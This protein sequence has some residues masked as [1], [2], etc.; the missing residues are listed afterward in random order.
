MGTDDASACYRDCG[1]A[2]P[3]CALYFVPP[4]LLD[5]ASGEHLRRSEYSAAWSVNRSTANGRAYVGKVRSISY[6][7]LSTLFSA[8]ARLSELAV[9][10]RCGATCVPERCNV[11]VI[12]YILF[13]ISISTKFMNTRRAAHFRAVRNDLICELCTLLVTQ[14]MH[15]AVRT[16]ADMV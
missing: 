1:E 4:L 7:D 16:Q 3:W 14:A 8:F 10:R 2:G 11:T 5:N 13:I 6:M 12:G 9:E 15:N